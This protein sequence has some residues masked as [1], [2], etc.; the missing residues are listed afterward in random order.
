MGES[1]ENDLL[2]TLLIFAILLCTGLII[3]Y[4][5]YLIFKAI[6]MKKDNIRVF[7]VAHNLETGKSEFLEDV[8]LSFAETIKKTLKRKLRVH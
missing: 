7:L 3:V 1:H 5:F 8:S 2:G 6:K 4:P